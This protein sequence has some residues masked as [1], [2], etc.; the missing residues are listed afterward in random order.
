MI[1]KTFYKH[2]NC[3]WR[4]KARH[5]LVAFICSLLFT[6]SHGYSFSRYG[7]SFRRYVQFD[8]VLL[9]V[10]LYTRCSHSVQ[11]VSRYKSYNVILVYEWNVTSWLKAII[12]MLC[13]VWPC[14][15]AQFLCIFLVDFCDL[16]ATVFVGEMIFVEP[17]RKWCDTSWEV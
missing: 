10:Q 1:I 14:H 6:D 8:P 2:L 7:Y 5:L 12:H 3:T 13:L 4:M 11:C 17:N 16:A 15:S 9:L